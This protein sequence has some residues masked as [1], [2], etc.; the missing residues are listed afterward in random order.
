MR[1]IALVVQWIRILDYESRD[2]G[3]N[4]LESTIRSGGRVVLG[5]ALQKLLRQFESDPDL[6]ITTGNGLMA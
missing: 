3:S 1:A 2:S 5:S 6:L 4:P